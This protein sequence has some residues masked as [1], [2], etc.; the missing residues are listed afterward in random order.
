MMYFFLST[1]PK[2]VIALRPALSAMS[3]KF[4]I[5]LVSSDSRCADVTWPGDTNVR[6]QRNTRTEPQTVADLMR[7]NREHS[8][9][10]QF[11][12]DSTSHGSLQG[13]VKVSHSFTLSV[14]LFSLS[15]ASANSVIGSLPAGLLLLWLACRTT[16]L[17]TP[18]LFCYRRSA[19]MPGSEACV[20]AHS[21]AGDA[22]LLAARQSPL[23]SGRQQAL[24]FRGPNG[25]PRCLDSDG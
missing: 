15:R 9:G 22:V 14:S 18:R 4:A 17:Q 23:L 16:S 3:T 2:I 19:G 1:P 25:P 6:I 7:G 11:V 5:C 8:A 24:I 12:I 20:L 21:Q 10:I 13:A